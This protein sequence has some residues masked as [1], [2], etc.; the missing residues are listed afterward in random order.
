MTILN[1]EE[2]AEL[3]E[4]Q[5]PQEIR[6]EQADHLDEE[7]L[8]FLQEREGNPDI[9]DILRESGRYS[10][11]LWENVPEV[12]FPDE[13]DEAPSRWAALLRFRVPAPAAALAVAA[14]L[15]VALLVLPVTVR[16]AVVVGEKS[17]DFGR[18]T[19]VEG[20]QQVDDQ[21]YEA[22]KQRGLFFLDLAE[23]SE[24]ESFAAP[25]VIAGYYLEAY[26]ELSEA[27]KLKQN[28]DLLKPIGRAHR[29]IL[30]QENR[31][32]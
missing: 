13:E 15:A 4:V 26:N 23:K 17:G 7:G 9:D 1:R 25:E 5:S 2:I 19:Q 12:H 3:L 11:E 30:E 6:L 32:K 28:Q 14:V 29:W 22:L 31:P 24:R 8:R 20:A 10:R 16:E 18:R 27:Y 21:L